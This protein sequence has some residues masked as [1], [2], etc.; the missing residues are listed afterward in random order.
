MSTISLVDI[1]GNLTNKA[2]REDL[3]AVLERARGA[4]LYG[5]VVAGVSTTPSRRGWEMAVD[6]THPELR[7]VATAGI[8]PHHASQASREALLEIADLH[9]NELV[10]AVGECGL[11]YN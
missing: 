3:P 8:H 10:V 6:H 1:A 2:F 4:G 7:L 5:I 9:K 11:D